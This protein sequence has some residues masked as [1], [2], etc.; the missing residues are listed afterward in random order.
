MISTLCVR[1]RPG[2]HCLRA[3]AQVGRSVL[4]TVEHMQQNPSQS[5]L[6][7]H[8]SFQDNMLI[9]DMW[10]H[11]E[12]SPRL[13]ARVTKVTRARP[14]AYTISIAHTAVETKETMLTWKSP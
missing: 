14:R 8:L 3:P 10:N 5:P 12:L 9:F 13:R 6:R 7:V 4:P 2:D 11:T 1:S